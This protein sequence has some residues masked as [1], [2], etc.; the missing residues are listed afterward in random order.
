MCCV[1]NHLKICDN[2]SKC[3]CF[4]LQVLLD[5][6]TD[7]VRIVSTMSFAKCAYLLSVYRLETLRMKHSDRPG[8][9]RVLFDYLADN[10][11][12]KDKSDMWKCIAA[13]SEKAFR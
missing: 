12:I 8:A 2:A 6:K 1:W 10:T 5:H 11:I 3:D 4:S 9:F 7:I 13:V